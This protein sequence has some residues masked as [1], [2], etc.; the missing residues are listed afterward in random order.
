M[1]HLEGQRFGR[2]VVVSVRGRGKD[3]HVS[4]ECLCDCG[5]RSIVRSSSLMSGQTKSCG[6]F[7]IEKATSH[8]GRHRPEYNTWATMLQRCMNPNN[9]S[10]KDYGGRGITVCD[11]WLKFENFFRDMGKRPTPKHSIDRKE[12]GGNYEPGN[13][14]WAT[15]TEQAMNKRTLKRNSTGITGVCF[16]K[17]GRKFRAYIYSG[18]ARKHLGFFNTIEEATQARRKG[19]IEFSGRPRP[20]A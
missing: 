7:Q 6:C 12:N 3:H 4:W 19:E 2:L 17:K 5:K 20:Q 11:D 8:N 15:N 9:P 13:C 1:H 10:Y 14:R 18:E 16:D